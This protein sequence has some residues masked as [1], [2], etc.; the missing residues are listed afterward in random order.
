MSLIGRGEG[1]RVDVLGIPTRLILD[2]DRTAGAF[3]L[4]ELNVPPRMGVPKHIHEREDETFIVSAGTLEVTCGEGTHLVETGATA[5]LPRGLPHGFV[6]TS[7]KPATLLVIISP[8][9]FEQFFLD[10]DAR[11]S[12]G[13]LAP[14]ELAELGAQYGLT[15][16][17]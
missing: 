8:G 5:F 9:G 2:R 13:D 6:N 10:L 7:S 4:V 14:E 15:F 16:V 12:R 17:Q 3:A 1:R 11:L